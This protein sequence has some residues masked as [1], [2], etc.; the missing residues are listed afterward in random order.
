MGPPR[1]KRRAARRAIRFTR[2]AGFNVL[3]DGRLRLPKTGDLEAV[4][5][6]ELPV[7]PSSV[8]IVRTATGTHRVSLADILTI[9][10]GSHPEHRSLSPTLIGTHL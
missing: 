9:G 5:S 1:F 8:T 3:D 7:V 10:F 6:G 4:W 2:N